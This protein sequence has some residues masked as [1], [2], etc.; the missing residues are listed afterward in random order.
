MSEKNGNIQSEEHFFYLPSEAIEIITEL[1]KKEDYK[2]LA[3]Y[4]D[5]SD[6]EIKISQLESGVFFIRSKPPEICHPAGFWRYKHPFAPGFKF[7][8]SR[9]TSRE[10]IY[11]IEVSISIDQG[12]D[13]PEQESLSYFYMKK[14]DEGWKLLP[15]QLD[16]SD[17]H[18]ELPQ[19]N[20]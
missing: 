3:K 1:L 16:E 4:Y 18:F 2:S 8:S 12:S 14:Y 5:L 19:V 11:I 6:S 13:S 7:S 20:F 15:D 10:N 9:E 17:L